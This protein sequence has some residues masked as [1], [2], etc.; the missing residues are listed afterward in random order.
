MS[1]TATEE[2]WIR[3]QS[4]DGRVVRTLDEHNGVELLEV[5]AE[6]AAGI[7]VALERARREC[8]AAA[9]HGFPVPEAI[10]Y[11]LAD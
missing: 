9:G 10:P 5:S 7:A 6:D 4:I 8:A 2:R 1:T 3:V 11:R